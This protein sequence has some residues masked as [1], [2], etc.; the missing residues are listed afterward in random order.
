MQQLKHARSCARI[1]SRIKN[2]TLPSRPIANSIASAHYGGAHACIYSGGRCGAAHGKHALFIRATKKKCRAATGH[3][4][5]SLEET[6]QSEH[7]FNNQQLVFF[8]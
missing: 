4:T 5:P 1:R 2:T 7:Y 3:I 6:R 8:F